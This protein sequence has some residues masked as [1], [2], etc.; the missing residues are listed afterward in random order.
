ML[1]F[2]TACLGLLLAPPLAPRRAGPIEMMGRAKV[3][4]DRVTFIDGE[5]SNAAVC[6]GRRLLPPPSALKATPSHR[7]GNN[8]MMQRK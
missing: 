6:R 2:A 5:S 3:I 1:P 4:G 7:A 8:L